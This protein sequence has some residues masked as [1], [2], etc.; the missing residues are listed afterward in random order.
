[1]LWS[2]DSC[3]NRISADQYHLTVARAQ[4]STHRGRVLFW[5]YALTNYQFQMIAGSSLFYPIIHMKYVVFMSLW[6]RTFKILISNWPRTLKF[7]HFF[8]NKGGEDFSYDGH[9]LVTLYV[10]FLYSDW[11]KIYR[12]V[13]AE[14]LCGIMKVVYFESRSWQ[15]FVSTCNVF[16][17]LFH[18]MYKMKYSCYQESSVIHGWFVY[19]VFGWEMRC[20]SKFGNPI[21]DC[22]VFV[23]HLA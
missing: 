19:W 17:C 9:A 6:P 22:I 4:V 21:S 11:S 8:K 13:H 3:E 14:N 18:R 10:Q 20:L 16:N 15:N 5:S 7:S 2:I 23:F 1:M 12:W